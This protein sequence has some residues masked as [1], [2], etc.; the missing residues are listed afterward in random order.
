MFFQIA[1]KRSGYCVG[2]S[3]WS[4]LNNIEFTTKPS[5]WTGLLGLE[6]SA[7]FLSQTVLVQNSTNTSIS[8]SGMDKLYLPY[9]I[10]GKYFILS[11]KKKEEGY[12]SLC[13]T[14]RDI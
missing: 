10:F 8:M 9:V 3:M 2:N 4:S 14:T 11:L 13:S 1:D 12:E 5:V 6:Q 7:K